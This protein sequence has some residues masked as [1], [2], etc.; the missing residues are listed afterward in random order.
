[1][2]TQ[3]ADQSSSKLAEM[4]TCNVQRREDIGLKWENMKVSSLMRTY[5]IMDL[6]RQLESFKG[7]EKIQLNKHTL[8]EYYK[9]IKFCKS[10]EPVKVGFVEVA[11]MLHSS[12]L[13]I[14]LVQQVLFQ[15]D[16]LPANPL[17]GVYKVREVVIQCEKKESNMCWVFPMLFDHWQHT[18]GR[19]QIP[20]RVL[21]EDGPLGASLIRVF[22]MK[23]NLRD[24]LYRCMET[25]Y[26]WDTCVKTEIRKITDSLLVFR[27]HMGFYDI[28]ELQIAYQQ[29]GQWPSSADQFLTIFEA[30]VYGYKL[31]S[32]LLT[33]LKNHKG[34]DDIF[35]HKETRQG[36]FFSQEFR[37]FL[38]SSQ[39]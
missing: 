26:T 4:F 11:Q 24:Y 37:W 3:V 21:Q 30:V 5:E 20:I 1:M 22:L 19:D 32:V 23:R 16:E 17:D 36:H 27:Q 38:T 33:C 25:Q 39:T 28:P 6:K 8:A 31:D 13:H 9:K 7:K 29:R 2:C 35:N 12:A 18:D 15:F 34:V 10:S 14:P